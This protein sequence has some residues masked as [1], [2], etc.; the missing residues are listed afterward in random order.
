VP[1][2]QSIEVT[3]L[4]R[5]HAAFFTVAKGAIGY[6]RF[7][8]QRA[9]WGGPFNGQACRMRIFQELHR[10]YEFDTVFET[11]T[12]RGS[13]TEFIARETRGKVRTVEVDPWSY[14]Y[15]LARF[16]FNPRVSVEFGDSRK[17]LNSLHC[18]SKSPLFFYLDAHWG[19]DLPLRQ[20]LSQI[21]ARWDDAII[22]IDD[23]QVPDDEHYGF[24]DYGDGKRLALAY[25]D[26]LIGKFR[27]KVYFPAARGNEESGAQRGCVVL[28]GH[29]VTLSN[30]PFV[31]LR[32]YRSKSSGSGCG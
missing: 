1:G 13:T 20:E 11:G 18:R 27:V 17:F 21:L 23:F 24:D 2:A 19:E 15:C 26:P 7:P 16:F 3:H 31:T 14:G 6:F 29:K 9:E 10:T 5:H 28:L 30:P 12:Y 22:M 32:E 8:E 4:A 25:I